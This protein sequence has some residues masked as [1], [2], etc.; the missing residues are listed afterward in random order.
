MQKDIIKQIEETFRYS[1]SSEK[2]FDAFHLAEEHSLNV[3]EL[4][5]ILLANPALKLDE[6]KMYTHKL[7]NKFP[8]H[9]YN[10]FMWSAEILETNFDKPEY[11]EEALN[12]YRIAIDIDCTQSKPLLKLLENY[13]YDIPYPQNKTI[14]EIVN[15]TLPKVN[16][17]KDIYCMLSKHYKKSGNMRLSR[18]FLM[19]AEKTSE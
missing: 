1:N 18:K 16:F 14:I 7:V 8:E 5:Q 13:N 10:F 2:L 11:L 4:Y 12:F 19:L 6:I 3:P 17:K 9:A 15:N